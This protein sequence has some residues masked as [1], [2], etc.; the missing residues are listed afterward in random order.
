MTGPASGFVEAVLLAFS[1]HWDDTRCRPV[2]VTQAGTCLSQQE[3][4]NFELWV[5]I[6]RR[7]E[8]IHEGIK[9]QSF[10]SAALLEA[11]RFLR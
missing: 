11:C 2:F 1:E 3:V 4:E 8:I 6:L 7:A 5:E 10:D 9:N